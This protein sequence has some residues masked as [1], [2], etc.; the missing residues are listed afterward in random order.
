MRPPGSSRRRADASPTQDREHVEGDG[1]LGPIELLVVVLGSFLAGP[2]A[3]VY[4]GSRLRP[5]AEPVE[6]V[7]A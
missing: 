7:S 1:G 5:M 3:A 6:P 4:L 2:L